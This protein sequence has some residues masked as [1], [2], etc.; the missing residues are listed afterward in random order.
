MR[1]ENLYF[2]DFGLEHISILG[3]KIYE[4]KLSKITLLLSKQIKIP[5]QRIQNVFS[6]EENFNELIN[7]IADAEKELK[8]SISSII[9]VSKIQSISLCLSQNSLTFKNTQKIT[10]SNKEKLA[11]YAINNFHQTTNNEQILDVMCNNFV[12]DEQQFV[13]NP[14]KMPCKKLTLNA[15]IISIKNHF[16]SHMS[17]ILERCKIHIKHYISS[18]TASCSLIQDELMDNKN[19]LFVDIGSSTTEFCIFAKGCIIYLDRVNLG[20]LDM[21]R[22]ISEELVVYIN[23]ADKVKK[24]ISQKELQNTNDANTKFVA[25]QVETIADARLIE[26][27]TYVKKTI[28]E[29]KKLKNLKLDTIF[30]CGGI[31][32]YKNT[33]KIISDIFYTKTKIL[34]PDYIQK[35]TTFGSKI[36]EEYLKIDNVQLFGA[37][38]FYLTNINYYNNAKRGFLFN[39]PSKISCLL[40]DLLY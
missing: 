37:L 13:K 31:A 36:K 21:T 23:D 9:L 20:G 11:S 7:I 27:I 2:V 3:C 29:N 33:T 17:A 40:K 10:Q 5:P 18:C 16:S 28:E 39:F 38:N 35:N 19:Y 14:Y 30:V 22:D 26:I 25:K 15:S 1:S 8:T 24:K 12:L 6:Q 32:K 4:N 34:T